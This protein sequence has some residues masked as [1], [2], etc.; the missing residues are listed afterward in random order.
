MKRAAGPRST[1]PPGMIGVGPA[2]GWPRRGLPKEESRR[3]KPLR[4]AG[5]FH[6]TNFAGQQA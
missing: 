1:K 6:G 3:S 5:S 2:N 4:A